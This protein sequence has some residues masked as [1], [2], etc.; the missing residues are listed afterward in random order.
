MT[1]GDPAGAAWGVGWIRDGGANC[2]IE[3]SNGLLCEKDKPKRKQQTL[4]T[5]FINAELS[6]LNLPPSIVSNGGDCFVTEFIL[7]LSM[8]SSQ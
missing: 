2:L 6:F 1:D 5:K 7:S 3:K 8:G 4:R